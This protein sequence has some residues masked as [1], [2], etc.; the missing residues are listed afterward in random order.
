MSKEE[1]SEKD[2]LG[3]TALMMAAINGDL[4]LA[5]YLLENVEVA[6]D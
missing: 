5:S 6:T 3:R 4:D 2:R 1:L